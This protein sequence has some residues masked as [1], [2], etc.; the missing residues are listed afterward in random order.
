MKNI[1]TFFA[2][3]FLAS[4]AVGE[5]ITNLQLLTFCKEKNTSGKSFCYGF[6]IST[7]NA[8]QFYRNIVDINDKYVDICF[9][10]NISNKEIVN[11]YIQWAEAN[12]D[13]ASSPA[14]IGVS[15]SFSQKYTCKTK[16]E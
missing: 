15:T 10:K 16:D 4:S 5:S 11:L 14:F 3:L 12:P 13:L 6:V 7:A 1:V 2:C 9:P 8:A